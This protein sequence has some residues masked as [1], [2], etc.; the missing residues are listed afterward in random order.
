LGHDQLAK[1]GMGQVCSV[2]GLL[3]RAKPQLLFLGTSLMSKE[4][5]MLGSGEGEV[6]RARWIWES[7]EVR[8][9]RIWGRVSEEVVRM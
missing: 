4:N 5:V 7:V 3:G 2:E 6:R 9:W 8:W 1:L